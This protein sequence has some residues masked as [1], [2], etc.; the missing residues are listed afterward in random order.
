MEVDGQKQSFQDGVGPRDGRPGRGTRESGG[1]LT[2]LSPRLPGLSLGVSV[3]L[4]WTSILT[5][6][7]FTESDT[8]EVT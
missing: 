8:T 3:P 2:L 6:W 4:G 5:L 7:D 1:A